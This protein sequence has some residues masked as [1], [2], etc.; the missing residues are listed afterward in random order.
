MALAIFKAVG[1]PKADGT[2]SENRYDDVLVV[3]CLLNKFFPGDGG[4]IPIPST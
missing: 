2:S 1:D 3:Q 4:R